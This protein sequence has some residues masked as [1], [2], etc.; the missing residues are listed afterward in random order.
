MHARSINSVDVACARVD[1]V[2]ENA[3]ASVDNEHALAASE[4]DEYWSF[5]HFIQTGVFRQARPRY[6]Y[7]FAE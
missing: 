5:C 1:P 4:I 2:D 6:N 3:H 7:F